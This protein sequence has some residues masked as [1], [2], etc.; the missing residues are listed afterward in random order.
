MRHRREPDC[1]L[2]RRMNIRNL[3]GSYADADQIFDNYEREHVGYSD[4][5]KP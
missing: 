2:G 5:A 1:E 3:P 4:E